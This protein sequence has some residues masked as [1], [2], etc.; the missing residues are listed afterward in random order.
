[1]GHFQSTSGLLTLGAV[2]WYR[3]AVLGVQE[4][5]KIRD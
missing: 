4:H 2:D 5:M 3:Q 1:M